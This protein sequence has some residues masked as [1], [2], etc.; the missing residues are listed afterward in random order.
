MKK[1]LLLSAFLFLITLPAIAVTGCL[2]GTNLYTNN[3][4]G[5]GGV[6][7]YSFTPSTDATT[8]CLRNG[9]STAA[10]QVGFFWGSTWINLGA[11]ALGDYG[12]PSIPDYCPVDDYVPY[13]LITITL[14]GF[15]LLQKTPKNHVCIVNMG[16]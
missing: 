8:F 2:A 16:M 4:G 11:G 7:Y 5:A 14:F 10:C 9:T 13:I 12:P 15:L 6:A 1:L 3:I